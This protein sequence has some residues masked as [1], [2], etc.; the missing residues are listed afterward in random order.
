MLTMPQM[1]VRACNGQ[2]KLTI[3][4]LPNVVWQKSR[5]IG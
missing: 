2:T 1:K 3:L 5:K 4:V